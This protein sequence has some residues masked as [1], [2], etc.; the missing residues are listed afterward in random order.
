MGIK[1]GYKI[2][3]NELAHKPHKSKQ[4]KGANNNPER[5]KI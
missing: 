3:A 1:L 4:K 5:N 2:K